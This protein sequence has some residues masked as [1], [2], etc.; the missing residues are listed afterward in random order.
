MKLGYFAMPLHPPGGKYAENLKED[1]DAAVL[2]DELGFSEAFFGEHATDPAER[3]TSSLMFVASLANITK[4]IKLGCGTINLPN[5]HPAA[6]ATQIAMLDHMLEGRF[7]MGI[8]AGALASDAE[9]FGILDD[10]RNARFVE[11]IDQIL[12][13]WRHDPPYNIE[14]EFWN[15]STQRTLDSETALGVMPK[16]YQTPHPEIVCSALAPFS[17]GVAKAAARGWHPISSNFLQPAGVASHWKQYLE[18]CRQ[19]DRVADPVN[20]RV[21]RKVFVADDEA[22][23]QRYAKSQEGPYAFMVNQLHKKLVRGGASCVHKKT[24]RTAQ[25]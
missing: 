22:T 10:D 14:G 24:S 19:G 7:I 8:S 12:K 6:F 17:P 15:I 3:I 25:S 11:C 2:A 20:W 16:P 5:G 4:R 1:R 21:A 9:V 18:G 13:I 23:A